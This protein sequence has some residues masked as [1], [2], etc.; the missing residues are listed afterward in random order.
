MIIYAK[1]RRGIH[2]QGS[3]PSRPERM[4]VDCMGALFG[5]ILRPPADHLAP[6]VGNS[7]ILYPD[8]MADENDVRRA[9]KAARPGLREIAADLGVSR[10]LLDAY[11]FREDV[12]AP[13]HIRHAL[14][15]YLDNMARTRKEE[16][17]QLRRSTRGR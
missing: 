2:E 6:V 5:T 1:R 3:N 16:A 8:G 4:N 14:A 15:D 17:K 9:L 7:G 12:T 11:Q 13:P 10:S